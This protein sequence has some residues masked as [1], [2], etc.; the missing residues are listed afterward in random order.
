[1]IENE[2][3]IIIIDGKPYENLGYWDVRVGDTFLNDY[4]RVEVA[5]ENYKSPRL[6]IEPLDKPSETV[7]KG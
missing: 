5:K 3:L 4:G 2:Y 1:M 7:E 6:L